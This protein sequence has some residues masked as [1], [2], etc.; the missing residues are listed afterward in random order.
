MLG[1]TSEGK[2]GM[3][4]P[5]LDAL[6]MPFRLRKLPLD[7]RGYPVPWFVAWQDGKPEFRAMDARKWKLAVTENRCWVCGELLGR[8]KTFVI[9]PMCGLNRTTAEPPCHT[10]CARWSA[11]NCPFLTRP[12]MVRREDET[13]NAAAH[14]EN[15]AGVPI[16]R[17]PG[18][19]LL[20]TTQSYEIFNDGNGRP[21]IQVGDPVGGVE[22]FAEGRP[23]TRAEVLHSIETGLPLLR[24]VCD[25]EIFSSRR[26]A[27]HAELERRRLDVYALLP[28]DVIVVGT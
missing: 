17:N 23:A 25:Q 16:L 8:W 9:G 18:V 14:A 10:D 2:T 27:A 11:T 21:L 26:D 3:M 20:W 22:W 4:R 5:E 6:N 15:G 28:K 24:E 7:E 1:K 13:F 19:T 12:H